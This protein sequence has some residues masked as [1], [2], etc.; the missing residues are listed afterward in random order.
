M[1]SKYATEG[2]KYAQAVGKQQMLKYSAERA[3]CP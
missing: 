3:L 2:K 1:R